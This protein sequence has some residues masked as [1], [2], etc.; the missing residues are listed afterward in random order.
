MHAC[1]HTYIH[2]YAHHLLMLFGNQVLLCQM[3]HQSAEDQARQP[4]L[5]D[6]DNKAEQHLEPRHREEHDVVAHAGHGVEAAVERKQL[7]ARV[8]V[9]ACVYVCLYVCI[10][11][12]M[13][14]CVCVCVYVYIPVCMYTWFICTY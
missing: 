11:A 12:C 10:Y 3:V 14:V 1:I 6:E 9:S 5:H 8:T 13:Y 2:I 4:D 7:R